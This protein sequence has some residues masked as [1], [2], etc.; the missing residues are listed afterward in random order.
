[1]RMQIQYA[2][3]SMFC[4]YCCVV[5]KFSATVQQK[6]NTVTDIVIFIRDHDKLQVL[7]LEH[8]HTFT[9]GR[10]VQD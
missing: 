6:F 4:E 1:M 10:T 8:Y 3:D 5:L 2:K 9:L 7:G